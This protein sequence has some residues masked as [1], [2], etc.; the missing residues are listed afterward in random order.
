MLKR[1]P[2]YHPKK[3]QVEDLLKSTNAG[4]GGEERLDQLMKYFNPDYPYLIIQDYSISANIE[5]QADTILLTQSCVILLEVKN[6]SG[7]LRFTIN[8]ST[9]HQTTASGV[10]RG[11]KSPQVQMEMA[12]W[13]FEKLLKSLNISLPVH[14]F[15]V[16]AYPNQIVEDSPPGSVIWS[17]DEVM[18]RLQNFKLPPKILSIDELHRF[19]QQLLSLYSEFD[20]FPLAPKNNIHPSEINIG[21]FCPECKSSKMNKVKR[22]WMCE[23][24]GLTNPEAHHQ[25]IHEWFMLIK[26]SITV[27]ECKNFLALEYVS[28]ARRILNNPLYKKVADNKT[29]KY[30]LDMQVDIHEK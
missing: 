19:G 18:I 21:V 15:L 8:P 14:V 20:P 13:K 28:T 17:A 22:T 24:C 7:R 10:E 29:K 11:L 30:Y 16:I 1:L 25:A 26:P 6:I 23:K 5:L 2:A 3:E 27:A 12:K 4:F 9:L